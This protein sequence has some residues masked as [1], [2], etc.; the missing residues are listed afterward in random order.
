MMFTTEIM[1]A[2]E[3][4]GLNCVGSGIIRRTSID[5]ELSECTSI[6]VLDLLSTIGLEHNVTH[7]PH[8]TTLQHRAAIGARA[9]SPPRPVLLCSCKCNVENPTIKKIC[10]LPIHPSLA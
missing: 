10:I 3:G 4:Q 5:L 1:I 7:G 6:G 9:L 2:R 8:D